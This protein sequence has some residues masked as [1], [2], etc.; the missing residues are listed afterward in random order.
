MIHKILLSILVVTALSF[1]SAGFAF[2]DTATFAGGCY[3][4]MDAEFAEIPGVSKVVSG[5][6]GGHVK[7]PTYEEVSSGTTGHVEAIEVTFDPAKI[8]YAKLVDIFWHNVDPTDEHGQFCDKGSQYRAAIFYHGD[9]QKKIAEAS[10]ANAKKI[11]KQDVAALITPA[12]EFYPA[13]EYHQDYY[14]K[15][16]AHYD[17]YH[18]GCGRAQ[19][20]DDLWKG[21]PASFTAP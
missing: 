17:M 11:L 18:W 5:Y 14:K 13:E 12:T 1:A 21:A 15:N 2:A 20:L 3:W 4:C 9:E 16:K 10:K 19:R 7:N 8:S 6:T